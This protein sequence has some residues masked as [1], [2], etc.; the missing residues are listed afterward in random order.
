MIT[1]VKPQNPKALR[2]S[3]KALVLY[4]L[5]CGGDLPRLALASETGLTA[6]SVTQIVQ[7]LLADGSVVERDGLTLSDNGRGRRQVPLHFNAGLY[8]AVGVNVESDNVHISVCTLNDVL[9]EKVY[10]TARLMRGQN[11]D[12]LISEI[13][14]AAQIDFGTK[15]IGV[16]VGVT[17]VTDDINGV[18]SDSYG[19][20]AKNCPLKRLIEAELDCPVE[21]VNNVRAQA[22]SCISGDDLNFMYVKHSP[23]IGAAVVID[24]K[25]AYGADGRAGEIGHTIVNKDGLDCRC[26]KKGCLEAYVSENRIKEAY[27]LNSGERLSVREIYRRYG[28]DETANGI[29]NGVLD[30]TALSIGNAA[31]LYDPK[32]IIVTGGIFMNA[33]LVDG[34][35]DR[36]SELGFNP[37]FEIEAIGDDRRIKAFAGAK[38][39]L[40]KSLF[41][42]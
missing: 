4:K 2:R 28:A 30:L 14:N 24:G 34:I 17:G 8:S 37:R 18:S 6:A 7:E 19:I 22:R 13:K 35:K 42:V 32:K 12:E 25:V 3:N 1:N 41:E 26:G 11:V 40:L 27:Y 36:L 31:T 33:A 39:I 16:G 15:F 5:W 29:L 38:H 23:G 10:P 20:I 9:Y 21:I